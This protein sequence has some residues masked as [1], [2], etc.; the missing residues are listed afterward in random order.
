MT[1]IQMK[2]K[3]CSITCIYAAQIASYFSFSNEGHAPRG[4][5][6]EMSQKNSNNVQEKVAAPR[7]SG[8]ANYRR[9]NNTTVLD[10]DLEDTPLLVDDIE[11]FLIGAGPSGDPYDGYYEGT[12]VHWE[13]QQDRRGG[14]LLF[15]ENEETGELVPTDINGNEG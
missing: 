8:N 9:P 7:A 1:M 10:S 3:C 11:G 6:I 13:Y 14:H 2:S 15:V 12:R 4:R 5:D